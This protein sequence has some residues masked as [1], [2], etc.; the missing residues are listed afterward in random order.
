MSVVAVI[1]GQWGDEGKGRIVDLLAQHAHMVIRYSGG[2][3]A[4]HTVINDRGVF[5]LHLIPAGIFNPS[6]ANIIGTGVVVDPASL[7]EEMETLAA[8][9]VSFDRLYISDRAHVILPYHREQD[10]LQETLR[11]DGKIGTTG[12]GVG[13]AYSDKMERIGL[14]MAD[15]RDEHTLR[16]QL[17]R[18][19]SMKN[20]FFRAL[21]G[22]QVVAEE[23]F[24]QLRAYGQRL[25]AH[26]VPSHP[27]V[28]RALQRGERILLEGAQASLLDVDWGTY[29]YVTSSAPGAAGACQG[30]G[31]GPRHLSRIL[32]VY[33]AYTTRVGGGPFPTELRDETGDLL[34]ERGHEYGTTTG[35]P[36]RCGWFDAVAARYVAELNSLTH[37][38]IT[39][40]DVLD[41]LPVIRICTGYR[42]KGELI[43]YMPT[44]ASELERV[45]P[46]YEELPGWQSDTSA[47][48]DY[49]AL[50]ANARRYLERLAEL[51]GVPLA[52]ISVGASRDASITRVPVEALFA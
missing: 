6:T 4:G 24:E 11:G 48:R 7:L 43:D 44:L 38:V 34:R 33:K 28:Q 41:P 1:G 22:P 19:A 29:P 18:A 31:I 17:A 14:R 3:N 42:L 52:I 8:A 26:I 45:E 5:K 9:D 47:V 27:L 40:L 16:Q 46:I 32:G 30:S 21:N 2:N 13:P 37:L 12:R 15:L 23:L 51:I 49:A 36:R 25:R 50:P 10:R 39:K 20:A 35:R